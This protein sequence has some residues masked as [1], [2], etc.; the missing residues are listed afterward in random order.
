MNGNQQSTEICPKAEMNSDVTV[1]RG[2]YA[3]EDCFWVP[4]GLR[5]KGNRQSTEVY[6]R[7]LSLDSLLARTTGRF[8]RKVKREVTK[9][10]VA[11]LS[12]GWVDLLSEGKKE[13]RRQVER[14]VVVSFFAVNHRHETH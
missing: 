7:R 10:M 14:Y 5:R 8:L 4:F 2:T 9:E 6:S 11:P 1:N 12:A 13:K 3:P